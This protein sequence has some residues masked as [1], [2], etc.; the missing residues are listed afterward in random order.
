VKFIGTRVLACAIHFNITQNQDAAGDSI[1]CGLNSNKRRWITNGKSD[2]VMERCA[3]RW[4][5]STK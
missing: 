2:S 3:N 4:Y 1:R 5:S